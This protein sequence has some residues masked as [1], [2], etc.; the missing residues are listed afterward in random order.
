MRQYLPR[1]CKPYSEMDTTRSRDDDPGLFLID[2]GFALSSL[3]LDS[4]LPTAER[5]NK[6]RT[7]TCRLVNHQSTQAA[8]LPFVPEYGEPDASVSVASTV[9]GPW[10]AGPNED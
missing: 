6:D 9:P 10:G 2:G 4:N 3:V 7:E 1:R 8:I 5:L